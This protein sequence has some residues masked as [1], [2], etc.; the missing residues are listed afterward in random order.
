MW[1]WVCWRATFEAL[2]L[3]ADV[4]WGDVICIKTAYNVDLKSQ[5]MKALISL[6]VL[7]SVTV[8]AHGDGVQYSDPELH[9]SIKLPEGWRRLAPGFA[10]RAA[11]AL[12]RQTGEPPLKCQAWFQ[13]SDKADG[14]YP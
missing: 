13:R 7:F 11:E 2:S 5:S 10:D 4:L 8:L 14:A 9:Y 12:A 6:L 3:N 1:T